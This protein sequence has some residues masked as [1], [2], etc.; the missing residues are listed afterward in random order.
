MTK[1]TASAALVGEGV[2][3]RRRRLVTGEIEQIALALFAEQGYDNVTTDDIARA[4]G[5][6]ARTFFRY[7]AAKRDVL[8]AVPRRSLVALCDAVDQRPANEDLLTSWRAATIGVLGGDEVDLALIEQLKVLVR[9]SPALVDTINGDAELTER[10]VRTNAQRLGVDPATDLRP[11]IV[12]GAVR[13]ALIAA[14]D[15]WS[16]GRADDLVR[17]FGEAF[18]I[19]ARLDAIGGRRAAKTSRSRTR[20]T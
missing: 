7:F 11:I 5:I 9:D 8:L 10:F 1:S 3:D 6:S 13:N 15:Q 20:R 16:S 4:C 18:D 2:W 14:L 17:S 12:A 19:L